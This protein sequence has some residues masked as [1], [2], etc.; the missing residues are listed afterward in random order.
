MVDTIWE[1]VVTYFD[2]ALDLICIVDQIHDYAV[3]HHRQFVMKHLEAWHTRHQKTLEPTKRLLEAMHEICL[4]F[5]DECSSSASSDEDLDMIDATP[6]TPDASRRPWDV[7]ERAALFYFKSKPTQWSIVKEKS[8]CARQR[9]AN[10]TRRRNRGHLG[11]KTPT[12]PETRKPRGRPPKARATNTE[13]VDDLTEQ[14]PRKKRSRVRL[15]KDKVTNEEAPRRR[16]G[17]LQAITNRAAS[18]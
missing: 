9:M 18:C 2:D 15:P 11:T 1:G 4:D 14:L 17:R 3:H 16:S 12:G 10:E 5:E 7:D 13:A 8:K 6:L